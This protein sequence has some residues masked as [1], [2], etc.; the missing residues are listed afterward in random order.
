MR[1]KR[2]LHYLRLV[3]VLVVGVLVGSV[4]GGIYYINQ[5]GVNDHW[6]GR[7]AQ[8]LE[9]I[10]VIADFESLRIEPTRGLVAGGVRVYADES[11][12]DILATLEH[13]V[14]DVDKTKLMRGILRVNKVSLKKAEISLPIDP[15]DPEGPRVIMNDLRGDMLL[16]DRNTVEARSVSGLVA[17][18][19]LEMDARIWSKH[20]TGRQPKPLKEVRVARIKL[21]ARI[22]Q[23]IQHWH[24]PQGE[25]PLLQLYLEGNVDNPDSARLDFTLTANEL[26]RD[27]VVLKDV[28]I[29]GDYKNKMVTLDEIKLSDGAGRISAKADFHPATRSGRFEA[30]SSLHVQML[31]RKL[32]GLDIL[33]QIT[34]SRPPKI[35]CTGSIV[36]DEHFKPDVQVTG[37]AEIDNFTCLGVPF[38]KL[39]T[40]VS[41]HGYDLFLTDLKASHAQGELEGR[42]LLKDETVRFE[43]ESTLPPAAYLAFIRDSPIEKALDQA[44]FHSTSKVHITA[45]GTINRSNFTEWAASGH[46]DFRHFSYKEVPMHQLS[47]Q[48][49]MTNLRSKFSDIEANLDY[50]DY[51]LRR[52][53][54]GPASARAT[55]DSITIDRTEQTVRLKNIRTTAWPAP[56]VKLF[57]S[58][59]AKHIET[60][61]FHRPPHLVADGTFGLKKGDARTNFRIDAR[62]PGSMNYDFL[63]KP[64]TLQ[65]LRGRVRIRH[66][67]VEVTGLSFHTFQ[68]PASGSITVRTNQKTPSYQG[69]FQWSRLHLK[70]IGQLYKFNNAERGLLT[71]RLDFTGQGNNMRMFNG[72]GSLGL[73]RGNL[74]SVPM[75]GPI[76]P[77]IGGVL[78][79]RNPTNQQAEDASC[80]FLIRKGVVLSNDFLA[81]TRSLKFTGEGTIDLQQKEI[82]LLVRMNARGLF[83]VLS[84]PLRPFMGLFQFKGTGPVMTPRWRTVIFTN[85]ARGKKDPIFR[86]PPKARVVPE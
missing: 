45:Q 20:L 50:S 11:R 32:F 86:K 55:V 4:I 22:I 39:T 15:D 61:R 24:W 76:S 44:E 8:E 35:H 82:D 29:S 31:A 77:L 85:P 56:I 80:T 58:R 43:A 1:R 71:G 49:D 59:V 17:G 41:S 67:R 46:A 5:T 2:L 19:E 74:F 10:G 25:P 38:T 75:L 33:T 26:E 47:G 18:I 51:W 52:R 81:T 69:E 84:L 54:G 3:I 79:K 64:L 37:H 53:H 30:D 60:Y 36:L 16:P 57:A 68:G 34:F 73:E 13:L 23:E 9:N 78:G 28:R 12:E 27:G 48:F 70:D 72:K 66:D 65:R 6:R 63:G 21:I 42:V 7:I 14:I 83:S 40:D 62:S